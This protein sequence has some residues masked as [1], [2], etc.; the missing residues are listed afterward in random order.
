MLRIVAA[1]LFS[2]APLLAADAA[3]I[4]RN[5]EERLDDQLVRGASVVIVRD[6]KVLHSRAFGEA[7][8]GTAMSVDAPLVIGSLS[9]AF[10]ATAVLQLV[11]AGKISLD[12]PVRTY[13]PE[14]RL[15]DETAAARISVRHLLNQTSGIPKDAP[16]ATNA[17]PT[18]ADHVAA[19]AAT[20]LAATPGA[21]HIYASPNYQILGL[22]VEKVSGLSFGDYLRERIFAPLGMTHSFVDIASARN[23]GLAPGHNIW[24]GLTL[25]STYR[26][27]PDR[28]PTA[29]IIT[30]AADLAR[31]VS[32]HLGSG[33][34]LLSPDSL[35]I[36]HL[37]V[38]AQGS[39]KYAMGW[40]EGETAGVKSLWHG[41]ALPSYRGAVVMLPET[42]TGIVILTNSSSMF[43][44]HTREIASGIAALLNGKEPSVPPRAL[45]TT[46]RWIA[47]L[48]LFF[49][50]LHVRSIVKTVR[51]P[52]GK[53][54][55]KV[56]ISDLAVPLIVLAFL[57]RMISV[58]WKGMYEGAPDLTVFLLLVLASGIMA[59]VVNLLRRRRVTAAA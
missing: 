8:S 58:S 34:Q 46:Y 57:P 22:L 21:H 28:L 52:E 55:R 35:R 39:F 15:A 54:A 38:A 32:S 36:A 45:R 5:V 16:R 11:D 56:V 2:A 33:P 31:F 13:L 27:E 10:T 41:G 17:H 7:R 20:P 19:L 9:K 3:V 4:D 1:F 40:R 53:S 43:A 24:F 49:G 23:A 59:G 6:G 18:L 26:H 50:A 29:S 51:K 12:A 47:L 30:S 37:G 44:D 25:P 42:K 14:F 48:A